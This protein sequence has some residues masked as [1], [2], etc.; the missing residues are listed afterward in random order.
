MQSNLGDRIRII[1][2]TNR[3]NQNE[4][5][6]LIGISQATLSELEQGKYSPSLETILSIHRVFKTNLSWL[7]TGD[8]LVENES[9]NLFNVSLG[10]MELKLIE[11]F[12]NLK[13]YDREEIIQFL[14]LKLNRYQKE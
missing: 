14:N 13:D 4:F 3:L 5:A 6:N 10:D 12:R 1:R 11:I 9:L 7:L 2:K 8:S